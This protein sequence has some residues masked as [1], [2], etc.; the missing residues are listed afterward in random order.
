LWLAIAGVAAA[1]LA[2][3]T[4]AERK[5]QRLESG[6]VLPG[7][8][9]DF[10]PGELNSWTRDQ[11][12]ARV[13]QSVSNLRLEFAAGRVTG[14]ADV[15]F[16]KLRQAFTG[17]PPGWLMQNLFA[18]VRPVVVT[19]RIQSAH[20]RA[21]VDVDRVEVS[22][23]PIE[24]SALDFLIDNF[25]RPQFPDARVSQWFHLSYHVDHFTVGPSGVSVF[26]G[27]GSMVAAK[28]GHAATSRVFPA[29]NGRG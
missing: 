3:S 10:T 12:R 26:V 17:E 13:S 21:R 5:F 6:R 7:S 20:G 16:V 29:Q 15:D 9:I 2:E 18:G 28:S 24:G 19:A 27:G 4:S 11:A 25:V 1:T 14:R 22:G 23:V 8:R